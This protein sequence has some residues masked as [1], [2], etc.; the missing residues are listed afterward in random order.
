MRSLGSSSQLLA[1]TLSPDALITSLS[2]GSEQ[3]T[4]YSA[5]ELVGLP[6]T[7]IMADFSAFEMPRILD[8]AK[9]WGA[10]QGE[11]VHRSR[12][13]ELLEARSA[14]SLLSGTENRTAGYLLI[15]D[16]NKPLVSDE[17]GNSVMNEVAANLRAFAHDLN[18]PLAVMM[19]FVQLIILDPN[20]EGKIRNDIEK[21]YSELKRVTQAVEKLHGYALSLYEKSP[22]GQAS[23]PGIRRA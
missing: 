23:N 22:P 17:C 18:N 13:G 14:I 7:Q 6:V 9:E 11:I 4:G 1:A 3:L 16:L 19:G 21:L 5:Q 2:F 8:I 20:C 12:G 15:S 10:W